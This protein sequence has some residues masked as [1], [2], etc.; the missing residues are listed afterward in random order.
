MILFD[1]RIPPELAARPAPGRAIRVGLIADTHCPEFVGRL[2]AEIKVA[3][4][5]VDL[6]IHAGDVTE[7]CTLEWLA[8]IAPVMAVLGDH[9]RRLPLP[10]RVE[11]ILGGRRFG[12]VHGN[13][14]RLVEEPLTFLGTITLGY[15]WLSPGWHRYLRRQFPRAE[16]IVYGHLHTAEVWPGRGILIVNPGGVYQISARA[17]R[18]R[19]RSEPSWFEW[20]F[21]QVAR[22][23]R[24][25]PASSVAVMRITDQEVVVEVVKV[26]E[27]TRPGRR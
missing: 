16:V 6:I 14:S 10:G 3:F 24:R 18:R 8:E 20:C 2:P 12:V 11:F 4:A 25:T 17:A 27:P 9:D 5:G 23:R 26:P 13:R 1:G 21:L 19:L 7:L 15:L 22:F